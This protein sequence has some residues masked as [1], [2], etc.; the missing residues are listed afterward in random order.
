MNSQMVAP[1]TSGMGGGGGGKGRVGDGACWGERVGGYQG[2][3]RVN[4]PGFS[5]N[6]SALCPDVQIKL[7]DGTP[8]VHHS[9]VNLL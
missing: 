6:P 2:L 1:G 9:L 7:S 8:T 3:A 5:L 4:S